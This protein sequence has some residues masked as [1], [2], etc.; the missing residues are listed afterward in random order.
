MHF[1]CAFPASLPFNMN[2]HTMLKLI[3]PAL[4][5]LSAALVSQASHAADNTPPASPLAG[6]W[7]LVA[8]DVI[9]PDNVRAPD[10]GAAPQGMLQIDRE[11][12]YTL[13]I[14]RAERPRFASGDKQTGTPA[15]YAAAVLGSST[16]F[17]TI[18]VDAAAHTL[19]FQID[20]ASFPNWEGQTQT[21]HY[22]LVGDEL[23]YR[24]VPRPNGDVPISVWHRLR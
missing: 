11:G 23:S 3:F 22:E 15:E 9:K 5:S 13:Q 20:K 24:V 14:F 7:S 12:R 21:R 8:A 18:K 16:H 17:G 4:L 10:F 1:R 19:T 6:T 2:P